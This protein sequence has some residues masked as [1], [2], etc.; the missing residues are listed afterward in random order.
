VA[1]DT[2]LI[3][4]VAQYLNGLGLVTY[5]P[6]GVTGDCFAES[7][8]PTPDTAVVLTLYD[9]STEPDSKLP[10]DEPRMQVKVRGG[11]DPRTSRTLCKQIRDVLHGLGPVTLPDGTELILSVCLQSAPASL[12]VD[13]NRRHAHVC[14]FRL[15]IVNRTT[16]RS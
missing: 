3:D 10:Y 6:T 15:E 1:D 2:D 8:P 9:D 5:D 16:H 12:G 13:D 14:N 4:G 7:M 11:P